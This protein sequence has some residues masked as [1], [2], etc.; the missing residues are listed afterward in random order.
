MPREPQVL[1]LQQDY[2]KFSHSLIFSFEA[3]Y[4]RCASDVNHTCEHIPCR[5]TNCLLQL[6][7]TAVGSFVAM[8][9]SSSI[10]N[11]VL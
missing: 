6:Q 10:C 2:K 3:T 9:D 7:L 11:T 5:G 1:T 8:T 4:L